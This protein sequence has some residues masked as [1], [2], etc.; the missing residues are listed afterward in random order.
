MAQQFTNLVSL[1]SDATTVGY[2]FRPNF[3]RI[4]SS[5]AG[6]AFFNFSS[7]V[8]A[9]TASSLGF[10]LT[11][12]NAIPITFTN[13]ATQGMSSAFTA[14]TSAGATTVIRVGAWRI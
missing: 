3:I 4:E 12:G 6:T 2:G 5:T 13:P 11:S 8:I 10:S 7:T 9:T 14:V 1:T